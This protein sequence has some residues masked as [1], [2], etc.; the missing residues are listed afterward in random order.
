MIQETQTSIL[1][2][3][4][5]VFGPLHPATLGQRMQM[6]VCELMALLRAAKQHAGLDQ[7][8]TDE[9]TAIHLEI[10]DVGIMLMEIAECLNVDLQDVVNYKM[11][12][13]RGRRWEEID[14]GGIKYMHHVKDFDWCGK[15]IN[16]RKWYLVG[17]SLTAESIIG[18][19]GGFDLPERAFDW[20]SDQEISISIATP[21]FR[22]EEKTWGDLGQINLLYGRDI[23]DNLAIQRALKPRQLPEPEDKRVNEF[24]A[25]SYMVDEGQKFG[26][27]CEI[28]YQFHGYA[29]AG[30]SIEVA[31]NAAVEDWIK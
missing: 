11:K 25:L 27:S 10:A 31:A 15:T 21:E 9:L 19:E 1:N 4:Q 7:I 17:R 13:N 23:Y 28:L 29:A 2:W 16:I 20:A 3:S 5:D 24:Q 12:V 14:E 30:E 8:P 18:P 26:L 6:E 22:D